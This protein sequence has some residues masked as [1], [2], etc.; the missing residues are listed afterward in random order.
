MAGVPAL[1]F[2]IDLHELLGMLDADRAAIGQVNV[3]GL[4]GPGGME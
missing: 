1:V 4:E 3:E 2:E